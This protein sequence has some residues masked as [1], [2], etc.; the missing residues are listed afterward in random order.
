VIDFVNYCRFSA[1]SLAQQQMG[2]RV[3]VLILGT[4]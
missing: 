2:K 3:S 4:K 1:I